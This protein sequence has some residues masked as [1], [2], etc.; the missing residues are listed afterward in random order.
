MYQVSFATGIF[1]TLVPWLMPNH[2]GLEHPPQHHQ[3]QARPPDRP[4]LDRLRA[5]G[6]GRGAGQGGRGGRRAG[7]EYGTD[8]GV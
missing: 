4:D 7:G 6:E 1:A 8:A 3:P 5:A 2:G